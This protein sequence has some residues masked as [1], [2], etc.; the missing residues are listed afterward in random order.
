MKSIS[1][2]R[3]SISKPIVR[4]AALGFLF[5]SMLGPW[6]A[7][8]HPATEATCTAPLVWL[9]GGYCACLRSLVDHYRQA[10]GFT[11]WIGLP[12][13]LPILFT[14]L[15]FL[16]G[17]HRFLWYFHLAGWFLIAIFSLFWFFIGWSW[18]IINWPSL[19][20]LN[21]WGAGLCGALAVALLVWEFRTAKHQPGQIVL[22]AQ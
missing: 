21:L 2:S 3:I 10:S 22:Q 12:P 13:M 6:F 15:F 20:A 18:L 17:N 9:G 16:D 5:L 8:A 7:D 14:F 11:W 4:L 19:R 1:L